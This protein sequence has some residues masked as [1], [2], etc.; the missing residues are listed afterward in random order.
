MASDD[1]YKKTPPF[2]YELTI[3]KITAPAADPNGPTAHT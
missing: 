1:N 3:T 2:N